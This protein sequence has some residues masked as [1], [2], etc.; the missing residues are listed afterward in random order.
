MYYKMTLNVPEDLV[1]VVFDAVKGR[2]IVVTSTEAIENGRRASRPHFAGGKRNKGISG[3]ELILQTL[4]EHGRIPYER[5][6]KL[7]VDHDPP[8]A[9]TSIESAA[10]LLKQAGKID[11]VGKRGQKII[12]K[13]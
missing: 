13:K 1:S 11:V 12:V 8:F 3:Q 6:R 4:K 5:M 2:G 7:F 10:V 9:A